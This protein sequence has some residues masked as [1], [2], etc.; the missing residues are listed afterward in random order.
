MSDVIFRDARVPAANVIG[1]PSS[2]SR[3]FSR[4]MFWERALILAPF[5]GA[6]QRQIE[7]CVR[8]ANERVQ[9][10]KPISAYQAISGKIVDMQVRLESARLLIY[11]AAWELEHGDPTMPASIA[12]LV[13][14]EAAVQTFFGCH[15][16]LWWL[17][18]HDGF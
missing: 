3:I 5:L 8:Y 13:T 14:S 11:K 17:W 15:S 4:I 12:K 10:G 16:S 9:F 6:M 2:G 7:D 1:S 18:L